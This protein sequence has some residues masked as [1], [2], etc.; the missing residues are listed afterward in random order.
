[1]QGLKGYLEQRTVHAC[2]ILTLHA[3]SGPMSQSL[4]V[5][6]HLGSRLSVWPQITL[7]LFLFS[8]LFT[9]PF[10]IW[11]P[12]NSGGR[13]SKDHSIYRRTICAARPSTKSL[14]QIP[15]RLP[16]TSGTTSAASEAHL[17]RPQHHSILTASKKYH[18]P[19]KRRSVELDCATSRKPTFHTSGH[20]QHISRRQQ[21]WLKS[22]VMRPS[23]SPCNWAE[24]KI[25][26]A[27]SPPV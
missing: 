2:L 9:S 18:F 11:L 10:V 6:L 24:G 21:I 26:A 15:P 19:R 20:P 13:E 8:V 12:L 7:R 16:A 22:S 25:N 17:C 4:D 27:L 14:F 3:G 5:L 23:C 1:M